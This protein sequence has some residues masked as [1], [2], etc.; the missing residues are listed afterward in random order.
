M[1]N[2]NNPFVDEGVDQHQQFGANP[3][4]E[5][6]I[7][8]LQSENEMLR[9]QVKDLSYTIANQQH[10]EQ[11][12]IDTDTAS[13]SEG[14]F[15]S[16]ES[17]SRELSRQLEEKEDLLNRARARSTEY[18][19]QLTTYENNMK[20]QSEVGRK[21]HVQRKAAED[22]ALHLKQQ[23]LRVL[24]LKLLCRDQ[25]VKIETLIEALSD[26]NKK[27]EGMEMDKSRLEEQLGKRKVEQV[28]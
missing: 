27:L 4:V 21:E 16:Y 11:D 3:S 7:F 5:C 28:S 15:D 25:Q 1:S 26:Q 14:G 23:L 9:E 22:D 6:D 10:L 24:P 8:D 19:V 12:K 18:L 2:K 13:G 17:Q 20:T